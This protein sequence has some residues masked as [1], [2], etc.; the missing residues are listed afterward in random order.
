MGR[1]IVCVPYGSE[2]MD[3]GEAVWTDRYEWNNRSFTPDYGSKTT[4]DSTNSVTNWL[5]N[6]DSNKITKDINPNW[7]QGMSDSSYGSMFIRSRNSSSDDCLAKNT[8]GNK[9]VMVN[10][11]TSRY[12]SSEVTGLSFKWG[13]NRDG[14]NSIQLWKWGF[15]ITSPSGAHKYWGSADV[16]KGSKGTKY[17]VTHN[18]ESA[19]LNLID[20]PKAEAWTITGLMFAVGKRNGSGTSCRTSEIMIGNFRWKFRTVSGKKLLLP[21]ATTWNYRNSK[22]Y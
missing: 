8:S 7:S 10:G 19:I 1:T 22:W 20:R 13:Y 5:R 18:F 3:L 17:S 15:R 4:W 14:S 11:G 9:C 12:F 21:A 16:N 6:Y 2:Q